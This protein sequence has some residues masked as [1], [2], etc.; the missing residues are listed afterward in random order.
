MNVNHF[1]KKYIDLTTEINSWCLIFIITHIVKPDL[2]SFTRQ[3][4]IR[5]KALALQ[6]IWDGKYSVQIT[7]SLKVIIL[8]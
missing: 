6:F 8:E 2:K 5:S 4:L 7:K 3:H 1:G